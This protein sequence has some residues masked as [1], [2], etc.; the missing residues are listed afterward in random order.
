MTAPPERSRYLLPLGYLLLGVAWV[1]ASA[2]VLGRSDGTTLASR[3][4]GSLQGLGLVF[5][6]AALLS[7]LVARRGKSWLPAAWRASYSRGLLRPYLIFAVTALGML[8][9]G[10]VLYQ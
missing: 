5:V 1:L 3:I 7:L 2:F 8:L 6:S 4:D 9:A 10:V